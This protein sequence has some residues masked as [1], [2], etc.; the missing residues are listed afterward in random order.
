MIYYIIFSII[1]FYFVNKIFNLRN[2]F[3]PFVFVVIFHFVFFYVGLFYKDVYKHIKIDDFTV[4]LINYSFLSVLIGG[5]LSRYFL[6]KNKIRYV[7]FPYVKTKL[8]IKNKTTLVGLLFIILGFLCTLKYIISAGGIVI[9][10]EDAENA[11]IVT[12]KGNGLI[13]QLAINFFTYGFLT[14]LMVRSSISFK[15]LITIFVFFFV[16]SFGNRGPALFLM[17]FAL[18]VFQSVNNIEFSFKKIGIYGFILFSLMVLF[19]SLR[20]NYE[21]DLSALFKARFAWR[22]F[23]NI[24]NFQL[25]LD[26]FPKKHNFLYGAT[27]IQDFSM[28]LPGSHPNSGNY[29]K[30]LMG[31]KFDGGSITPSY[32]GI[33][34]VNFGV[35]GLI[36]SPILL[37]FIS[38]MVYE[39]YIIKCNINKPSNL[40]LL[41]LISFNFAAIISSGI[42]TVAVQNMTIII[43]V[44][45]LYIILITL[46]NKVK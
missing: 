31:L 41:I 17:V 4:F 5:V 11:R 33:S 27:Y 26:Y 37:G 36:L 9:F 15:I 23:V 16:L 1:I 39:I 7:R 6:Q 20:T 12:R 30:D 14:I 10:M 32:L 44:H 38:N 46:I 28:L 45:F 18:Y 22:P 13:I 21:A 34:F 42:M 43:L 25:V 40:I 35:T 2:L 29:L 8:S 24:Q 3:N 19:G